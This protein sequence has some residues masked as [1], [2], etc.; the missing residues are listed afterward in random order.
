MLRSLM[1]W[2]RVAG[3]SAWRPAPGGSR[4]GADALQAD[5]LR[6]D[7]PRAGP[8]A[9]SGSEAPAQVVWLLLGL[10]TSLWLAVAAGTRLQGLGMS[11]P[12]VQLGPTFWLGLAVTTISF[13]PGR[14][15][16]RPV[17]VA[18]LACYFIATIAFIY[19]YAVMHDSIANVL[20]F[21][22]GERGE[23]LYST[24]YSGLGS[25]V[26]WIEHLGNFDPW[27]IA[28]FFPVGMGLLYLLSVGLLVY[29]W[30]GRILSSATACS[31]F[32]FFFFAF[33]AA[34]YLRINAA[35]QTLG[36]L[37]FLIAIGLLPLSSRSVLL[38]AALLL[39]LAAMIISHPI[40]PL[41]ATPGLAVVAASSNGISAT[42]VKRAIGLVGTFLVGYATWLLYR[43][44][45]ILSRAI[46]VVFDAFET[47]KNLPLVNSRSI[48]EIAD[49]VLLYRIFLV[50]LIALLAIGYIS[51]WRTRSWYFV[52]AWGVAFSPAFVIFLSY[53][54][55][56]DRILL[57]LLVPCAIVFA[58][59]GARLCRS[60]PRLK[61][62]AAAVVTVTTM[63]SAAVSYFWIG[64]VDHVTRDEVDAARYLAALNRPLL[65]YAG[66][67]NLPLSSDLTFVP[68][69]RGIVHLNDVQRSDAV[70]LPQQLDHAILLTGRSLLS[71]EQ[72]VAHMQ[73][74][75]VEVYSSGD[76]RVFVKR[77]IDVSQ[78]H[79]N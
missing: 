76:T 70:V 67:F 6:G 40:T 25:A 7:P 18:L 15:V 55:F 38:K 10:G 75:F 39:A 66:G 64:A 1:A 73:R 78:G 37:M 3:S 74:D 2:R 49:F 68:A 29:S 72:M 30:R 17:A 23:G 62:P 43:A 31:L 19:P 63:L 60:F 71:T 59:A 77:T 32:S 42:Q 69:D 34:F 47:D 79:D 56:F 41:L 54:D 13:F 50:L 61:V 53:R 9:Y 12:F 24:S 48:S 20:L 36:Y 58:E 35:P 21:P 44:D 4:P 8:R 5:A 16:Q 28:R 65:V 51:L 14:G 27:E 11:A 57:F 52:T 33:G 46:K 45:W 26:A 22:S